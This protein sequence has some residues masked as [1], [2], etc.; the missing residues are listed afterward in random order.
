M[1]G[2]P[3]T[4][5][6]AARPR[7]NNRRT[8]ILDAAA[9][10]FRRQGY[11]ATTM[12]EVAADANMLAGSMYYHF[13]SKDA[14]LLAVHEEGVKRIASRV[15]QALA[16][17]D[18]DDAWVRMEAGLAAHLGS[19]L[20]GGDYAQVVIR[21]L[22]ADDDELR[23]KLISLRDSY[24]QRFRDLADALPLDD[25]DD[26]QWVR[27]L[28]LGAANWSKTWFR[29]DGATPTEIAK[30]FIELIRNGSMRGNN[31]CIN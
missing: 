31:D 13:R 17:A 24:E 28:L 20:D 29:M 25:P 16:N 5:E 9:Y 15:D 2:H 11:A 1:D 4:P 18:T 22:P 30:K 6:S 10:R 21:D 27:L 7:S 14:L 23:S 3:T 26:A 8:A 19:L 12:R